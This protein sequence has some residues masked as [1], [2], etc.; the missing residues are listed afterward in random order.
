MRKVIMMLLC[1]VFI[2]TAPTAVFAAKGDA[3]E[4][5]DVDRLDA[6]VV[7]ISYEAPKG[8]K[9]KVMI[10]KGSSTYTYD[11]T[12]DSK[13]Y[14]PLQMKNGTYSITLL[15][16]VTNTKYKLVK[17][18]DVVLSLK[19]ANSVYL[20]SVQNIN[21]EA[22]KYVLAKAK[23]VT[24]GLTTDEAKVKA[25]YDFIVKGVKYDADLAKKVTPGYIP[26]IDNVIATKK[27]ICYDY[28]ALFAGMARSIGIPARLVMGTT[29]NVKG[30]HAWNDVFINGKWVTVDTTVDAGLL[31]GKQSIKMIKNSAEYKAEKQY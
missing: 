21:W 31:K 7:G 15:E 28:A 18:K 29:D 14:F 20:E 9:L 26:D 2:S 17:S 12:P 10:K 24:K 22:S 1:A 25:I 5:L 3:A 4:W 13:T 6:G 16:G 8:T 23:A 27:G 19:N 30:Y 11:L